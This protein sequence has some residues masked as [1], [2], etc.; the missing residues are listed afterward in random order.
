MPKNEGVNMD[1]NIR[2]AKEK[3]IEAIALLW[4]ELSIDQLS[5]DQYYEGS[6]EFNVGMEQFK[7]ALANDNCCIFVAEVKGDIVGFIEVWLYDKDFHFFVDDYAYILHFFVDA[8]YRRNKSIIA[9]VYRL[10]KAAEK[11]AQ[12]RDV[13]IWLPTF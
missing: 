10:F 11:W 2:R 4:K 12:Q 7:N 8:E 13:G 3:D 5:K 6:M 9:V 1:F